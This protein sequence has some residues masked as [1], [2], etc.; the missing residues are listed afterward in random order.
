VSPNPVRN[1]LNLQLVHPEMGS[2]MVRLSDAQG[3]IIGS[4]KFSKQ[5]TNWAQ[6]LDITSLPA[7]SY[8]VSVEGGRTI[9]QV[10]Q[11]VKE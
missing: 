8:F 9:K 7:G 4:W 3:K 2:L 10:R 5:Q 6:S 11:F 1:T